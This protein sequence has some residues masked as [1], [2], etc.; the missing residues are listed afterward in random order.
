MWEEITHNMTNREKWA[1]VGY[2]AAMFLA[3]GALYLMIWSITNL[4]G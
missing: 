2:G 4:G 3:C 1:I